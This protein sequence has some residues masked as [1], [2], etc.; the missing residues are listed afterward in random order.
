MKSLT[1]AETSF[2]RHLHQIL[3]IQK[4]RVNIIPIM[5][6][7]QCYHHLL[8]KPTKTIAPHS[9][10]KK[11]S[12]PKLSMNRCL[13]TT[14]RPSPLRKNWSTLSEA[15]EN[16]PALSMKKWHV[17]PRLKNKVR[18]MTKITRRPRLMRRAHTTYEL[19]LTDDSNTFKFLVLSTVSLLGARPGHLVTHPLTRHEYECLK[20]TYIPHQLCV[21]IIRNLHESV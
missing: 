2:Q 16:Y 3:L 1:L 9:Y 11:Y 21:N 20:C 17:W 19:L 7:L 18:R 10:I 5:S 4:K 13:H 6:L 12:S 14:T 8:K 15:K